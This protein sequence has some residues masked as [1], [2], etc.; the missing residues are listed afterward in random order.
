MKEKKNFFISVIMNC[1][2]GEKY[3][4]ESIKSVISQTYKNWELIFCDN[5]SQD[6]S[7]KLVLKFKDKRIKYY[8]TSKFMKLYQ[9]RNYAIQK[10]KGS[11]VAFLDVDDFWAK[12]KLEKQINL[13]KK[14]KNY[15]AIYSNFYILRNEKLKEIYSNKSLD[16]GNI[17]QSLLNKYR[18]NISTTLVKKVLFKRRLFNK[19]YNIIGDFDYFLKLSLTNQIGCV[20]E[21]LAYY[22]IHGKNTS[23]VKRGLYIKELEH[24]IKNNINKRNT[25]KK[26]SMT[27]IFLFKQILK[28]K[29]FLANKERLSAFREII[30]TPYSLKKML[31][32]P[33]IFFPH[34]IIIKVTND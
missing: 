22:R 30:R 26:Y 21:K 24:W 13:F 32:L 14:N 9:A 7:K 1:H 34:K 10:S 2:N 6:Q 19:N 4:T 23:F 5:L 20:R 8:K 27:N 15:A 25:F 28:I 17:T 12:D 33:L 18:I 3:L 31:I 29:Y 11:F 16:S